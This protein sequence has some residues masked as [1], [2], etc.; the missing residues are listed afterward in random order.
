MRSC[1]TCQVN[2]AEEDGL[3]ASC[4]SAT[5]RVIGEMRFGVLVDILREL[6]LLRGKYE[7][8]LAIV[9]SL[10][11]RPQPKPGRTLMRLVPP[12]G[13]VGALLWWLRKSV[14]PAVATLAGGAVLT[15][16]IALPLITSTP[17]ST[18]RP[19]VRRRIVTPVRS[20]PAV[21]PRTMPTHRITPKAPAPQVVVVTSPSPSPS[22][23]PT[24][25]PFPPGRALGRG[26]GRG[27]PTS[28][29]PGPQSPPVPSALTS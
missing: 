26:H 22:P 5:D 21:E 6:S 18:P 23:S 12:L 8:L 4:R 7:E 16:A 27:R 3:C 10:L 9:A 24:P 17:T 1:V 11:H 28:P 15:T 2:R 29:P 20:A 14:N 13:A 19:P 25:S